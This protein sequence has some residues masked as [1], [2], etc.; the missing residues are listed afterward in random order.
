VLPAALALLLAAPEPPAPRCA[1]FDLSLAGIGSL[2]E[3]L[4]RTAGLTGAA[5][6]WPGVSRRPSG[7]RPLW[8][9]DG[10]APAREALADP[11]PLP[12][13]R[14]EVVPPAALAKLHTGWSDDRND[15]ALWAGRGLSA[16]LTPGLRARWRWLTVQVAPLVA[17]QENRAYRLPAA[18]VAGQSP[19]ANPFNGGAIDL[20][21]RMGPRS[22]ATLD[23]GQSFV[24]LDAWNLALGLSTENLWW[25]PGVRNSLLMSNSA[26]GFPHL[27][28]GTSRPL[29]AWLGFVEAEVTWGR[30]SES[31]WFDGDRANDHRLLESLVLTFEP[32]AARGLTLGYARVFVFPTDRVAFHHYFDALWQPLLKSWLKTSGSDGSSPD[33]Q[34]TSLF[35]RWAMPEARFEL[36]GE[37]GRDDH[38][39][40]LT[41]LLMEP[42]HAQ[43]WLLGLQKL[44]RSGPGWLR[45]Q[46]E[47]AHTFEL[48]AANP[49]RGTPIFYTH[50]DERQ[51][52]TQRGQMLGAGLGPQ[53]D[54]QFLALDWL[55][56]ARSL[57]LFVERVLRNERW[58]HDQ[59]VPVTEKPRHDLAMTYGTRG[60]WA[61]REW[62]LSWELGIT[63]R[64]NRD[65]V[66]PDA[67]LD[68]A[69]RVAW[70]P[71]R[72][73]APVLPGP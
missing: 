49:T 55:R 21:L 69:L 40:G 10:G 67:G 41:D 43:A 23:P 19:W 26:A 38:A 52:Y 22:F 4:A 45:V 14:L 66:S 36:Y 39:F 73:E 42:G 59:V 20:P 30:L 35:F 64:Y 54:T 65:F 25:G 29:D 68:A 12:V 57:G 18:A 58:F 62:S 17:W 70:W 24:R 33:N 1:S 63:H 15:A 60:S 8:L 11:R 56:G 28:L 48:P 44:F 71:G 72:E 2:E 13:L 50:G 37:W 32:A 53:G 31:R 9:C 47:A 51:G 5:P 61:L 6:L 16:S 46:V 7:A 27:F 3:E 34:L